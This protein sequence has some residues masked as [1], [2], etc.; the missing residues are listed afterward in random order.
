M[1]EPFQTMLYLLF[2][3]GEAERKAFN[4]M[5]YTKAASSPAC[6]LPVLRY[7]SNR[8]NTTLIPCATGIVVVL[9]KLQEGFL[10]TATWIGQRQ[11]SGDTT[12]AL[13]L[14]A[15]EALPHWRH[16]CFRKMERKIVLVCKMISSTGGRRQ[17]GSF[18]SHFQ[19]SLQ[20][21]TPRCRQKQLG[22]L[23]PMVEAWPESC[24]PLHGSQFLEVF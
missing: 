20:L 1:A 16:T 8:C 14:P 7:F 13:T 22:A 23:S 24:A 6:I 12:A 9:Q 5:S 15:E 11:H 2:W 10:V 21:C 3:Q 19:V 18:A 4:A 17:E